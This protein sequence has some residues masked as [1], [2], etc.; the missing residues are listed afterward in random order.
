MST[1]KKLQRRRRNQAGEAK[2]SP[3]STDFNPMDKVTRKFGGN[4]DR[5]H[6]PH[7]K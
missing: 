4:S 1:L 6:D 7:T 5:K 2:R 3:L